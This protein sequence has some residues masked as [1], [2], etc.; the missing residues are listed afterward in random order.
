MTLFIRSL[1]GTL[2]LLTMNAQATETQVHFTA[3]PE[4]C[5]ALHKGQIC[6]Q[7]VEFSWKT[8]ERGRYCLMQA[9]DRQ[10]LLCWDGRNRQRYLLA[11]EGDKT[12]R[13][14]LIREGENSP[15]AEVKVEVTWVYKAPRQSRS[16]WRLF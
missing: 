6:Y 15:L 16:G 8:P 12:T 5:I 1:W 7:D 2:L 13:Y 9:Q 3:T 14:S 11:F 10:Q 4:R